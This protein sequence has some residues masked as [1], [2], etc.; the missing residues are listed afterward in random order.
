MI[1][2]K[3]MEIQ[4]VKPEIT[5]NFNKGDLIVIEEKIDGPKPKNAA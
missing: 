4:V 5:E 2:K 1:H 3:Y